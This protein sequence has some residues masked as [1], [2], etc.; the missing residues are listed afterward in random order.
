ML[1][2]IQRNTN[3]GIRLV[4]RLLNNL[5]RRLTHRGSDGRFQILAD[6]NRIPVLKIEP[7]I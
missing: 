1:H 4:T 5:N 2:I 7:L 6:K 3:R